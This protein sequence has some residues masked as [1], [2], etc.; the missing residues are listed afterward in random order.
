M[1]VRTILWFYRLI[2]FIPYVSLAH[3]ATDWIVQ[4]KGVVVQILGH[5]QDF[6]TLDDGSPPKLRSVLS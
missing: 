6:V 1:H 2:V 4:G 3:Q 5:A